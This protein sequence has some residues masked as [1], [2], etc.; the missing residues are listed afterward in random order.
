VADRTLL[1][2]GD[3]G[4]DL[5]A[6]REQFVRWGT[7]CRTVTSLEEAR[8]L[9]A[10]SEG[11]THLLLVELDAL[12]PI[13]SRADVSDTEAVE[14]FFANSIDMLCQLDFDGYFRKL[15]PAWEKTLGFTREELRARPFIEF[16]HPEDRERTL[17]Q[18]ARVRS[19]GR[20]LAFE[21]RYLHKDGSH[22]WFHWNAAPDEAT[23]LIYSM[24]RDITAQKDAEAQRDRLV[25]ELRRA[26]A[27]VTELREILPICSYCRKIRD[28]GN[29]WHTVE[30]YLAHHTMARFSHG[31]C[32]DCLAREHP[33]ESDGD[34]EEMDRG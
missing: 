5:E 29:Y 17:R 27:E 15:N 1:I 10:H 30:A 23:G 9:A 14:R 16:V 13:P 6:L 2:L 11:G 24:A 32:P 18:N 34:A 7:E 25:V 21:N 4:A 31:I 19:G 3:G 26:L 8:R 12:G 20:A 28:D 33:A 22:R